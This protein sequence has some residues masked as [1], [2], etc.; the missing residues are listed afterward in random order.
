MIFLRFL[1][2]RSKSDE[3]SALGYGESVR[4]LS[5]SFGAQV[6]DRG[7]MKEEN[8]LHLRRY[9]STYT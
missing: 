1:L 7:G 9:Q 2:C 6:M 8:V 3:I 4:H 5:A